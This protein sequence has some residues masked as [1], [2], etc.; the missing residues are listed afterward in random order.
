[1]TCDMQS[2][3][4]VKTPTQS[5]A[6]SA[7]TLQSLTRPTFDISQVT[8]DAKNYMFKLCLDSKGNI[9][10][11]CYLPTRYSTLIEF[12]HTEVPLA[13]RHLGLGDLLVRRAFEWVEQSNLLVI[14]SCPFVLRYLRTHYPDMNGGQWKYIVD[15]EMEGLEK[16]AHRVVI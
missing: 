5:T 1:M 14:P 7:T 11:L 9:A 8:H 2:K 15:D 3:V 13:Y 12:Y 10:A 4:I 16:L 6:S